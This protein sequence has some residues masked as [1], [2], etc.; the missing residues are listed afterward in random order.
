MDEDGPIE[1]A[2][3]TC[4]EKGKTRDRIKQMEEE[5][6]KLEEKVK[7]MYEKNNEIEKKKSDLEMILEETQKVI[8]QMTDEADKPEVWREKDE[9]SD[10]NDINVENGDD[11]NNG[12]NEKIMKKVINDTIPKIL[13]REMEKIAKTIN[14]KVTKECKTVRDTVITQM[15]KNK[16]L[17]ALKCK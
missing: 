6:E 1:Y 3:V 5:I 15:E 2:C 14:D 9:Q 17:H 13:K 12:E 10:L 16:R 8:Q 11:D 4:N 7:E